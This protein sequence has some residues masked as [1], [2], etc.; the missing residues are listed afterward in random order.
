[1]R[2]EL[3]KGATADKVV[4]RRRDGSLARTS[5][6]HKGP[7]PHDA[8]HFF[9][10]LELGIR[11]G[12]WGLVAAGRQPDEIAAMAKAAGHAS[13]ARGRPP[14]AAFVPAIQAERI[15]ECFEANLWGGGSDPQAFSAMVDAACEQSL[16]ST[17]AIEPQ[18]ISRT[19]RLLAAFQDR[20]AALA[21]GASCL[22]EWPEE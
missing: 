20:W 18:Q 4:I 15:V 6:P 9:V 16:V 22:L 11:A 14:D 1:M 10:E 3:I 12:F 13:A 21:P 2:I 8:V 19:A 17:L 5:F 7:V